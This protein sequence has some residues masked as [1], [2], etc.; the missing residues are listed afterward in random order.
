MA[1]DITASSLLSTFPAGGVGEGRAE[2]QVIE[3]VGRFAQNT[4]RTLSPARLALTGC[5]HGI[6]LSTCTWIPRKPGPQ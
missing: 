1:T 3:P 6:G 2:F 4:G 5:R